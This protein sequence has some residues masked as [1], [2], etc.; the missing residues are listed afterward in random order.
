VATAIVPRTYGAALMTA[1]PP[2]PTAAR[3]GLQRFAPVALV[4]AVCVLPLWG[5]WRAPG[6]PMEEGFML[7]FPEYVL[8]GLVP[9]KDFLHLYGPGGLWVLAAVYKVFGVALEAERAVGY[10]QQLG[11]A[12]GVFVAIRPWGRWVA[13]TGGAVAAMIILPPIGLVALAW[14]GAVAL[15][16]WS[17]NAAFRARTMLAGILAGFALLYRPDLVL[18]VGASGLVLFLG[19]KALERKRY[20]IGA[21]IGVSPY[22]VHLAMAGVGNAF[23]GMFLDPVFELRGGRRLPL[24]PSWDHF[25]GFLQRA[26][27]LAEPPWPFPTIGSPAQLSL[28]LLLM[29][30]A[31]VVL[32]LAGRKVVKATG[33]RRLMALA[34][35]S[36]G[37]LPQAL[38]RADSTHL[39]WVS[40]IPF[41]LL[42]AALYVLLRDRPWRSW[43]AAL[44]PALVLL[45][46]VPDFTWRSYSDYVGQTFG[47]NRTS[48]VMRNGDRIFYYGRPDA[49]VAVNQL[50][51]VVEANTEP[52]DTLFVGTGDLRKT[53]YSE[54]FL[55]YLL[56]DLDPATQYIE[57]DPGVANAEDSGLADEVRN[58]DV[59]ILSSIRDDWNEPNDSEVFGPD[60]PNQV[61]EEEFCLLE[62]FGDGLFGRGLYEVYL[63]CGDASR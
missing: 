62:S 56:P 5:L 32:F 6:A 36:A 47:I 48:G 24:P 42:P 61:V 1:A 35:F 31:N 38:Q 25:D 44:A 55:Y 17:L 33:D 10:L 34:L 41:G 23:E 52:G 54:A 21:A 39:A 7:A 27:L 9:N 58:A 8:E 29:V 15:G 3:A 60:E 43:V 53:A 59:L 30:A 4:A 2:A 50:L 22:L 12:F 40:C 26:G 20:L 18:A 57:M 19:M 46:V 16:L 14:V 49:V 28:W 11:I 37:L 63:R 13:A 51:P 45:V